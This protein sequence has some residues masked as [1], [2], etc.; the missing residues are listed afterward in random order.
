MTVNHYSPSRSKIPKMTRTTR[1]RS[2][3]MLGQNAPEDRIVIAVDFGTTFS[4]VATVYS[5]TPDEVD[6][7]RTW[8]GKFLCLF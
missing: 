6:I 7:I 5:A 1:T 4:G 3:T 8:P 2:S